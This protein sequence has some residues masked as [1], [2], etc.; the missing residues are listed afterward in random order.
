M[1]RPGNLQ[2]VEQLSSAGIMAPSFTSNEL[3][4]AI[5]TVQNELLSRLVTY[6]EAFIKSESYSLWQESIVENVRRKMVL[7]S[8]PD[9]SCGQSTSIGLSMDSGDSLQPSLATLSDITDSL[10]VLSKMKVLFVDDSSLTMKLAGLSLANGG[11]KSVDY[12]ANGQVALSMMKQGNYDVVVIDMHMPV[13]DGFEAA[14]LYREYESLMFSG[15]VSKRSFSVISDDSDD[16]MNYSVSPHTTVI[17]EGGAERSNVYSRQLIIGMSQ[18]CNESIRRRA[19][20]NGADHFLPKPFTVQ[21][22]VA[23][24]LQSRADEAVLR[25]VVVKRD[26]PSSSTMIQAA[27]HTHTIP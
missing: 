5:R 2:R 20:L 11:V 1:C 12:A 9:Y 24:V 16:A 26:Y 13:M 21:K 19:L 18:D 23:A 10:S 8:R 14:R 25:G 22:L 17:P 6:F 15:G 7:N 4:R 3:S 27:E